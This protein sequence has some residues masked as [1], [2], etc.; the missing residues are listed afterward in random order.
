MCVLCVFFSSSFVSGVKYVTWWHPFCVS[1]LSGQ[2]RET[3]ALPSSPGA[4]KSP[5]NVFSRGYPGF[6]AHRPGVLWSASRHGECTHASIII[7]SLIL[8]LASRDI[9]GLTDWVNL[10]ECQFSIKFLCVCVCVCVHASACSW[11]QCGT[12]SCAV[13][14]AALCAW[15]GPTSHWLLHHVCTFRYPY[16]LCFLTDWTLSLKISPQLLRHFWKMI[17]LYVGMLWNYIFAFICSNSTQQIKWN[18]V[19]GFFI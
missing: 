9:K 12:V 15:L 2:L 6:A 11:F 13:S 7:M 1:L 10:W 4:W 16:Y 14:I 8:K 5:S 18:D 3:G 17:K 19:G